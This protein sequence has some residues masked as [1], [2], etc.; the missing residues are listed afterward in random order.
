VRS[1]L[2]LTLL[3]FGCQRTET[4][5]RN[6]NLHLTEACPILIPSGS[7]GDYVATGDY[8]PP[9]PNHSSLFPLFTPQ[10]NTIDGIPQNVQSLA[11]L[12][13]APID[14]WFAVALV[15]PAGDLDML[16]LPG[17]ATCPLDTP[18]GFAS[19]MV[20]GVVSPRTLIASGAAANQTVEPQSYR[21]DLGTGQV[22]VMQNGLKVPRLHAAFAQ[23]GNAG[24]A[25]VSGGQSASGAVLVGAQEGV[26]IFD[27]STGDF[28][29]SFVSLTEERAD[30]AAVT[31]ADGSVLLVG[32]QNAPGSLIAQTDLVFFNSAS[33]WQATESHVAGVGGG[34][35]LAQNRTGS[36][37]PGLPEAPFALRLAD[38]T[39]MVGG[40]FD[41][42][43]T[44][45][46]VPLVEFFSADASMAMGTT[47]LPT[48]TKHAF[49]ALDGGGALFVT[50]PSST[51]EGL[52]GGDATM[53]GLPPYVFFVAPNEPPVQI[54]GSLSNQTMITDVRLFP[55]AG[56]E[57]ILWTGAA[58][59]LLFDPWVGFLSLPTFPST[60]PDFGSPIASPDP[61]VRA[62]VGVAG[63]V[64]L[65]RDST[66]NEFST[67]GPYLSAASGTTL[68]APDTWQVATF[69]STNGVLLDGAS[70]FVA[71]ARYLDVGID[72]DGDAGNLPHV[73][74]RS[75][76][77]EI[78]VGGP[79]CPFVGQSPSSTHLY[80]ERD[81]G[82]VSYSFGGPLTPCRQAVFSS[83]ARVSVGVRGGTTAS[84]HARNLTI[85]RI[86]AAD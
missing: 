77:A 56:G 85:T 80:V 51:S 63:S 47:T 66:R 58:G 5:T 83:T 53:N 30:H 4:T 78:E 13:T 71:D 84:P 52:C 86:S 20:F 18:V 14:S 69:D 72:V 28:A 32:G 42:T 36:T 3:C 16:L 57:A 17:A 54:K 9:T 79:N 49:V 67:E 6:V 62:W 55:Y 70:V 22:D 68:M 2:V 39:I 76:G 29:S 75:T 27:A 24:D 31:L 73:V 40:G 60:G 1:A 44:D 33:Q 45:T 26:E 50:A 25:L 12:A 21:I 64:S 41:A 59:W 46:P 35:L 38:G 37:T 19:G 23:L 74:V 10:P 81:G 43:G 34:V 48:C 82:F 15:P 7:Y 65:W 8:E 61:G 11:L